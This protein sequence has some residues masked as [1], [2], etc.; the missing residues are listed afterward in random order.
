[1]LVVVSYGA[2]D[3]DCVNE[4]RELEYI[5]STKGIYKEFYYWSNDY[6]HDFPS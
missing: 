1:M 3:Q 6:S 2:W 5:F 4:T